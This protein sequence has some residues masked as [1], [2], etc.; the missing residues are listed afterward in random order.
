MGYEAHRAIFYNLP[1]FKFIVYHWQRKKCWG[2]EMCVNLK[3]GRWAVNYLD[4]LG[5]LL[6]FKQCY[7]D[8]QWGCFDLLS[9]AHHFQWQN[10]LLLFTE[11]NFCYFHPSNTMLG[12]SSQHN[13]LLEVNLK[14]IKGKA[15]S[16]IWEVN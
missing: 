10:G 8:N 15:D 12:L 11:S 6:Y 9:N 2:D 7:S 3:T 14:N 1:C 16:H 4:K 13:Q 5:C